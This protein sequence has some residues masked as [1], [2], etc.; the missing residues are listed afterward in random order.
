MADKTP[1]KVKLGADPVT[2]LPVI[3]H[4]GYSDD[5][6]WKHKHRQHL[7]ATLIWLVGGYNEDGAKPHPSPEKVSAHNP[8]IQALG[9]AAHDQASG[10]A[11]I[12][13]Q[14]E[15]THWRH[16]MSEL[17]R[18]YEFDRC[19]YSLPQ[20]QDSWGSQ[21]FEYRV[22]Q[23]VQNHFTMASQWNQRLDSFPVSEPER[24]ASAP[25]L[26]MNSEPESPIASPARR[27]RNR[28][29]QPGDNAFTLRVRV[30]RSSL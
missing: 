29:T 5:R 19:H 6:G 12:R 1:K 2:Y 14:P 24:A 30:P 26:D 20:Y 15:N 25:P 3:L 4:A 27:R 22:V 18:S 8:I 17:C 28:Q 7:I 13:H 11:V 10:N 21:E 16:L 23:W 9:G